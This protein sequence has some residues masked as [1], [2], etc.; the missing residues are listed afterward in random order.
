MD[1]KQYLEYLIASYVAKNKS[2]DGL[3]EY[4]QQVS[5]M[6]GTETKE[7]SQSV[8]SKG[9]QKTLGAGKVTGGLNMYPQH[10]EKSTIFNQHGI[11]NFFMLSFITLLFEGIF[12]LLSLCIY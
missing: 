7:E 6:I 1:N 11:V 10:Q 5:K 9:Y 4:L 12:I 3:K 8:T 2:T